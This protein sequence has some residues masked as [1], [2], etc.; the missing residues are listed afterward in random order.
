MKK[1]VRIVSCYNDILQNWSHYVVTTSDADIPAG[2]TVTP[3][4]LDLPEL[5]KLEVA[6]AHY[7]SEVN[8]VAA[9]E[10]LLAQANESVK[11][12]RNKL[13][14]MEMAEENKDE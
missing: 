1:S 4:E 10:K 9:L 6:Q 14:Q 11:M 13:V 7:E 8:R 5:S 12:A 3:V 2:A